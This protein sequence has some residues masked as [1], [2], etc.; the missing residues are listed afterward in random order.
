MVL[1]YTTVSN[2]LKRESATLLR[3]YQRS[4]S[5]NIRN[6][7]VTLNYGLVR[8]EAHYWSNQCTESYDD[9]LQVGSI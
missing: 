1:S 5:C 7:L 9:L 3:D 2:E 8:Q 4:R 6:Q